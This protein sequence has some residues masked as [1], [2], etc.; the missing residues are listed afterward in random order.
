M[1]VGDILIGLDIGFSDLNLVVARVNDFNQLDIIINMTEKSLNFNEDFKLNKLILK[2][3]LEKIL[4]E[5]EED[6]ELKIKSSYVTIPGIYVDVKQKENII[7]IENPLKGVTEEDILKAIDDARKNS[8]NNNN[9]TDIDVIPYKF[10]LDDGRYVTN[11]LGR[12][13][14]NIVMLSQIIFGENQYIDDV[15][16]VFDELDIFV[17]GFVP[18]GM[19]EKECF[20]SGRRKSENVLILDFSENNIEINLFING[21]YILGDTLKIGLNSISKIIAYNLDID[22]EEAEKLRS[23]YSLALRTYI[24][25]DNNILLKTQKGFDLDKK[26]IK[27]SHLIGIIEETL[28][29]IFEKINKDISQKGYKKLIDDIILTGDILKISQSDVLATTIFNKNI[30]KEKKKKYVLE[31][32]IFFRAYAILK[33]IAKDKNLNLEY[34][35]LLEKKEDIKL[36][37]RI[38]KGIK[39]FFYS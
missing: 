19:G 17:D 7:N 10:I 34:S 3:N 24:D 26:T 35:S 8:E 4:K 33:Y 29:K 9:Y 23:E 2:N 12:H 37:D 31:D 18:I 32:E 28:T 25:N 21:A 1:A 39:D 14:K 15:F 30:K 38:L 36:I 5:I 13:S 22:L 27:T 20:V 6:H 11:P 16:D